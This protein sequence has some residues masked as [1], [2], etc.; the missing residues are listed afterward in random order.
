MDINEGRF[1]SNSDLRQKARESLSGNWGI[2]IAVCLIAWIF[3]EM[4]LKAP[5]IKERLSI[6]ISSPISALFTYGRNTEF[7]AFRGL[8]TIIAL[9]VGGPIAFGT[10]LF[11]LNLTRTASAKI[12]DVFSGFKRFGNTFMLSLL[13]GIF[14]FLW[15]LLLIV[16]GIIAAFSYS[17]SFYILIDNPSLSASEAIERSKEMMSGQKGRLFSLYIS[18]AGWFILSILTFGIGFIW[19]EPYVQAS[20]AAFYEDLKGE[21][22]EILDLN[23]NEWD[24]SK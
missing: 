1:K 21:S 14:T 5:D 9:I 24:Y 8:G 20:T 13:M 12:E 7:G 11:F 22:N 19:L 4:Y 2:A 15:A 23:A 18:F 16:P 6:V 10:S 3:T 17:M